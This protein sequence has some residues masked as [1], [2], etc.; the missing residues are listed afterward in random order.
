MTL[1]LI[2]I[3][4]FLY[5]ALGSLFL[6]Q[7]E[8]DSLLMA[9]V[10]GGA[11]AGLASELAYAAGWSPQILC[12]ALLIVS[13]FAFGSYLFNQNF[14]KQVWKNL[15]HVYALY[16]LA[17]VP[18]LAS[19]FP[20]IGTW[21]GDWLILYQSGLCLWEGTVMSA[22]SLQRPPLFGGGVSLLWL[23]MDGLIPFQIFATV[24]AAGTLGAVWFAMG[25][26]EL[27]VSSWRVL[28]LLVL[29]PFFLHNTAACWGKLM[30]A[31]LLLA[32]SIELWVGNER[33]AVW[34]SA[35]LFA[36]AVAVHQ[37]SIIYLPL[38]GTI[39]L[40]SKGW[41]AL[42]PVRFLASFGLM[43]FLL[44]GM[45]E[46]WTVLHYGL[47]AKVAANPSIAQRDPNV[48]F[49]A[50]T[51]AVIATSFVG[52]APLKPIF[53]WIQA[54]DALTIERATKESFWLLSSWVQVM[55]GTFLGAYL[56]MLL[57][58]GLPLLRTL[59]AYLLTKSGFMLASASAAVI[60]LNGLLNPFASSHGTMQTGLVPLGLAGLLGIAV[61]LARDFPKRWVW[62]LGIT[63]TMGTVPWLLLNLGVLAG[64]E[65]SALFRDRFVAGSEGDW[66][67]LQMH[68]LTPL[69]LSGFPELQLILLALLLLAATMPFS[70]SIIDQHHAQILRKFTT[71]LGR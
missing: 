55:A 12:T 7:R 46:L 10:L 6:L 24:M 32:S 58:G 61:L 21:D 49:M 67:R 42:S 54:E 9:P 37:S 2:I 19:P 30:A 16:L 69:G 41:G 14:I 43:G 40:A 39:Q 27:R 70:R 5:W 17:L 65:F 60:L 50:N 66:D 25:R 18:A 23:F 15:L 1:F 45:F 34:W 48:S 53:R 20:I 3:A 52:T 28:V 29:T 26:L 31:G 13:L 62:G 59:R 22:E 71:F 64:L 47:E 11:V 51:A 4:P 33:S 35:G 38:V 63:T 44:V 56:P 57:A 8:D 36:L 68:G